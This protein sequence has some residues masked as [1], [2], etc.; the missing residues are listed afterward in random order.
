MASDNETVADVVKRVRREC[1]SYPLPTASAE[2]LKLVREIEA[3]HR[4]EVAE[5]RR[6]REEALTIVNDVEKCA[7]IERHTEA[8][9]KKNE[10]IAG[11]RRE[12]AELRE[13][14][15]EAIDLRCGRLKCEKGACFYSESGKEHECTAFKWRK[16]LE[17]ANDE[18]K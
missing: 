5:L 18:G 6:Q 1:N 2:M 3:A 12:V 4:R 7:S 14:L 13:C 8:M 10:V 15:K 17:G 11:L 16:A 9:L